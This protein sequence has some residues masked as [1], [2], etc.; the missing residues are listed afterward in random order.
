MS[1]NSR[2]DL[3]GALADAFTG[4][5]DF[6]IDTSNFISDTGA[7]DCTATGLSLDTLQKTKRV[8]EQHESKYNKNTTDPMSGQYLLHLKVAKKCID[9]VISLKT[10]GL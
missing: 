1:G 10:K 2:A 4:D 7:M 9:E 8:I 5:N 3:I 6:K